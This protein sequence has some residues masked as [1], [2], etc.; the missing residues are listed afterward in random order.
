[1]KFPTFHNELLSQS[2]WNAGDDLGRIKLV[3]AEGFARDS[4]TYPFER[5]KNVVSFSFQHAP[6]GEYLLVPLLRAAHLNKGYTDMVLEVLETSSIAWPNAAMWRQVSLLAPFYPQNTSPRGE[7]DGLDLHTHSP[8]KLPIAPRHSL[9]TE[10]IA[11]M[12]PPNRP[13]F[14]AQHPTHDPFIESSQPEFK[15]WRQPSDTSMA[16]YSSANTRSTGSRHVSDPMV[17]CDRQDRRFETLQSV[18]A[19][20]SLCEALNKPATTPTAPVNTPQNISEVPEA[21]SSEQIAPMI[22]SLQETNSSK[23]LGKDSTLNSNLT[24]P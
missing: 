17:V 8:R 18:G 12:P 13:V 2:Y 22:S 14:R 1:M 21:I 19:Y 16:D 24:L 20:D 4:L 9:P 5:I 15:K 7:A 23:S 10:N 11:S 6:L 3:I